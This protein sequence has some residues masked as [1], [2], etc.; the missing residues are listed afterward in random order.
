M[1]RSGRANEHIDASKDIAHDLRRLDCSRRNSRVN[2][3]KLRDRIGDPFANVF[4]CAPAAICVAAQQCE[5]R[6]LSREVDGGLQAD[7]GRAAKDHNSA[8][9]KR[10][11]AHDDDPFDEGFGS[12]PRP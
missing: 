9:R 6:T 7:A 5:P 3:D 8:L 12:A 1:A 2:L 4:A 10:F 11:R